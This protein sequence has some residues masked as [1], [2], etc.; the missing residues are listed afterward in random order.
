MKILLVLLIVI[1]VVCSFLCG[2]VLGRIIER[3]TYRSELEEL[4]KSDEELHEEWNKFFNMV[5]QPI[6]EENGMGVL[7]YL[8][9][10]CIAAGLVIYIIAH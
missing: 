7:E 3:R 1:I 8:L 9:L 6:A 5:K 4:K 10:L 2:L